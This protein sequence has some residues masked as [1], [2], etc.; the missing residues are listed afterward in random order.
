M[1]IIPAIDIIDGKCVRL[2]KGDYATKK[3][4][5][6]NPLEIAKRFEKDGAKMIHVVDLDAAKAGVPTNADLILDI[7]KQ[8]NIPLQ[9]GGGIR[10]LEIAKMYLDNGIKRIIIGTR[11]IE[12]LNFLK[13][14]ISQFGSERIVISLDILGD[15]LATQGWQVDSGLNYLKFAE[16]IKNMGLSRIVCTDISRDGMLGEPNFAVLKNLVA[17]GFNVIASGGVSDLKSIKI[18]KDLNCEAAIVG[19]AIY[20]GKVSI[21]SLINQKASNLAKRIIPCLDVNNGRVVKGVN[22]KSLIDAGDP[23]ELAKK[24]CDAGADELVFLDISASL[25]ARENVY[26]L[27]RRVAKN[28]SIPFTVGGGISSVKQARKIL[29]NGADKVAINSAAVLNPNLISQIAE[30]FGRQCVV[31][32][33]D[34]KKIDGQ[35]KVFIKGGSVETEWYVSDWLKKVESLGAGEILLTSMDRDGTKSGFDSGL[36]DLA[37]R[38]VNIPVIASG[39]AG[40]ME[41]FKEALLS[42]DAVLAASL[43]HYGQLEIPNLKK[44]LFENDITIRL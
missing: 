1:L 3:V 39:G 30:A 20:E 2:T 38:S 5:S 27:V 34:A 32:A 13:S 16:S 22:F 17:K 12:S 36:L 10:S 7:S 43:F 23:I 33:I 25:E 8:V 28:I 9:V 21:K 42:A 15:N 18:L 6:A 4:Y 35:Y 41:D 26:S 11:A 14:L 37:S 19:K 44:F 31:I 29:Q 24:Y 40:S